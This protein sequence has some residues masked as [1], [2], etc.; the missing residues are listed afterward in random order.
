MSNSKN[1]VIY[2]ATD[3]E[4]KDPHYYRRLWL[5][6]RNVPIPRRDWLDA[7]ADAIRDFDGDILTTTGERY[8][9]PDIDEIFGDDPDMRWMSRFKA[10][11]KGADRPRAMSNKI[12]R[13]RL[14]DLYFRVGEN[15]L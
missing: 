7:I 6:A 11:K 4:L 3:E 13:L 5:A 8:D 1:K 10:T 9:I 14:I 15:I 2:V 12:E